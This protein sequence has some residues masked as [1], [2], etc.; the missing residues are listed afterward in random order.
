MGK[1][2]LDQGRNENSQVLISVNFYSLHNTSN[3]STTNL[4]QNLNIPAENRID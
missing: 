2:E 4:S 3:K 1:T